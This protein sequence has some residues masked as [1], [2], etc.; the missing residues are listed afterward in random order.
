MGIIQ[1]G[2]EVKGDYWKAKVIGDQIEGTLVGKRT[3]PDRYKPGTD[4]TVYDIKVNAEP[5][6]SV[7]ETIEGREGNIFAVFGKPGIDAQM[8]Y[9]RLGQIIGFKFTEKVPSKDTA[10]NDTHKIQVYADKD[11]VDTE[12]LTSQ[13]EVVVG[14]A[15]GG[16]TETPAEVAQATPA[17]AAPAAP[18][19]APAQTTD[20][21][22]AEIA[23]LSEEKFGTK[24]PEEMKEKV[25][26]VTQL[27]F[28]EGNLG[29]I[30]D[31]IKVLPAQA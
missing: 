8:R 20:Q 26:E 7:G 21:I 2:K 10:M 27:A 17:P 24:T 11:V 29:K 4:Q 3:A 5:I 16:A 30:R 14:D 22:L 13:E 9:I 28:I 18:A 25:M 6:I 23:K 15:S 12:W 19:A 1:D 31:A